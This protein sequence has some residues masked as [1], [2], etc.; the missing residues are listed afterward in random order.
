MQRRDV[1]M[2]KGD[3]VYILRRDRDQALV[4][5]PSRKWYIALGLRAL[6]DLMGGV[7]HLQLE[8]ERGFAD[9][10]DGVAVTRSVVRGESA[11]Q[12]G[13]G[14]FEGTAWL[15]QDG[16]LMRLEGQ[17]HA[18]GKT[19]PVYMELRHLKIGPVSAKSFELPD[20]YHG[21]DLSKV[22]LKGLTKSV[23]GLGALMGGGK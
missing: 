14:S 22:N 7:E 8:R 15:T 18:D 2:A 21:L 1:H 23:D 19:T 12:A 5:Y 20:G 16:I 11:A 10:V 6:G 17:L 13:S 4:I 3:Q 9:R